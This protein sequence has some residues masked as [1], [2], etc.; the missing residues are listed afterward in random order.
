MT[1][2]LNY[3]STN[4]FSSHQ[5]FC[6]YKDYEDIRHRITFWTDEKIEIFGNP[7]LAF[8]QMETYCMSLF[9]EP[10]SNKTI[11]IGDTILID[12]NKF[13]VKYLKNKIPDNFYVLK[14]IIEQGIF[15]KIKMKAFW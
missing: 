11:T 2:K 14:N 6:I 5:N 1:F 15:K 10:G 13:E 4:V 9:L 12:I 8:E 3:T 7:K